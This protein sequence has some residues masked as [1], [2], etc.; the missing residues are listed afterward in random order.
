[1]RMARFLP[2]HRRHDLRVV[3]WALLLLAGNALQVVAATHWHSSAIS[4]AV[5]GHSQPQTPT[6]DGIDHDGCLLCQVAAHAGNA[7]PPPA[8]WVQHVVE[9]SHASIADS[10][11]D[12]ALIVV[13]S[14]AWQG[15]AP[16]RA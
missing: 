5:A 9:Q 3:L 13:P 1:M 10:A 4:A 7:A 12:A 6:Q 15:R 2:R 14:H 8:P 16:P 11:H